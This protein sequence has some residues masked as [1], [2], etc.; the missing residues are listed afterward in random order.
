MIW[1]VAMKI[2]PE[3]MQPYREFIGKTGKLDIYDSKD[4]LVASDDFM[5]EE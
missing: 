3:Y 2:G 5:I 1:G 4:L